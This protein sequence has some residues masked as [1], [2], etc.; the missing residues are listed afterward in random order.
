MISSQSEQESL[1]LSF[2]WEYKEPTA[3]I[4]ETVGDDVFE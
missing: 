3:A 4:W 1:S 2:I